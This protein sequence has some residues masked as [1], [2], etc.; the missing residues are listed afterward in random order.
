[1]QTTIQ[2]VQRLA[3]GW[4]YLPPVGVVPSASK[5]PVPAPPDAVGL[6]YRGG[7]HIVHGAEVAPVWGHEIIGHHGL[8]HLYG[9]AWR[10]F[11][12]ALQAGA[13]RGDQHLLTLRDH[14]RRVYRDANGY[15]YLSGRY[16]ADEAAARLV[17]LGI[18]PVTGLFEADQPIRKRI[19]AAAFH[20]AR[21]TLLLDLPA[22]SAQLEGALLEAQHRLKNGTFLRRAKSWYVAH[23]VK[24][25]NPKAPPMTLRRSESLLAAEASRRADCEGLKLFGNVVFVIVCVVVGIGGLVFALMD[26][27]TWLTR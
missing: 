9:P 24:P 18:N 14:V 17:E 11:M 16:E 10:G 2:E 23:M 26:L 3:T 8:R 27:L 5:L 19:Q 12:T 25:W 22:D 15:S 6:Y 4:R 21:E 20:L 7:V 1:M 13:R